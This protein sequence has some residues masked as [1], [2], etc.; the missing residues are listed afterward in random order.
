MDPLLQADK[1]REIFH[2]DETIGS[3]QVY[4]DRIRDLHH[5]FL[6][7]QL[8]GSSSID[9]DLDELLSLFGD[10]KFLAT[11]YTN[12]FVTD[13]TDD[14]P[15]ETTPSRQVIQDGLALSGTIFEYLADLVN[16]FE[17]NPSR[18]AKRVGA[19]LEN[20]RSL[21]LKSGICYG[22]GLYESR[23]QVILKRL[24]GKLTR[25]EKT[26]DAKN[27]PAWSDYLICALMSRSL[28]Q[29][30]ESQT[31]LLGQLEDVRLT[32]KREISYSED[33]LVE[34]SPAYVLRVETALVTIEA[35]LYATDGLLSG[36]E[37]F[38]NQA[39]S[40]FLRAVD[41]AYHQGQYDQTWL[42]RSLSRVVKRMW[43]H[44]PWTQ[45]GTV[46]RQPA[47]LR[48]L[49]DDGYVTLWHSQIEALRMRP[50]P[51]L[52]S[53]HGGYLDERVS[54]VVVSMPTSAGKTLLAEL[55]IAKQL[56][57][58]PESKCIYVAP[59]RALR[60]QVAEKL[61]NRL[62][63]F[64]FRVTSVV[65]D[66]D[67]SDYEGI[68]FN[69]ANVIV[70]TPEKL[71]FLIRQN[72]SSINDTGLFIFDELHNVGKEGRGWTYEE[73]ISLLLQDPTTSSAKMLF[74]SA[75]M[76]NHLAIRQWVDP[77][78]IGDTINVL[79]QPT[80][81]LKGVITFPLK[82]PSAV[83]LLVLDG[84]L[85]YVRNRDEINSPFVVPRII[86]SHQ[87]IIEK[88]SKKNNKTYRAL[89]EKLS[90][91]SLDH[92]VKATQKFVPLG[93]VLIYTPTR[94]AALEFCRR[95]KS[96]TLAIPRMNEHDHH[97]YQE[98]VE[99]I[100]DRLPQGH[101][102]CDVL[103]LRVAFHHAGLP[104]EVRSE[105][106]YA[107]QRGWIHI[108]AA[109]ST[110][111]EGVN[112]PVKT[113]IISDYYASRFRDNNGVP[114]SA[115][116]L[117]EADF[118]NMIGRA[119]RALYETEGQVILI[120]QIV[121]AF[122]YDLESE[123][124]DYLS[125][126]P[127]SSSLDIGSNMLD[128]KLLMLLSR[129]V[130]E[131][132]NGALS[133]EQFLFEVEGSVDNEKLAKLIQR[134]HVFSLLLGERGLVTDDEESFISIFQNTLSGVRQ[135]NRVPTIVGRFAQRSL[136]TAKVK[137]NDHTR[138]LFS[139]TGLKLRVC[140]DLLEKVTKF[141]TDQSSGLD[142]FLQRDRIERQTLYDIAQI[143][144]SLDDD[145]TSPLALKATPK[146]RKYKRLADDS[147]FFAD[148]ILEHDEQKLLSTHFSHMTDPS[149][150]AEQFIRY[151]QQT[152]EMSAPWS[153]SAFWIFSKS[154]LSSLGFDLPQSPFGRELILLPAYAKF[155]VHSPPAALFSSLG[156]SPA[157]LSRQLAEAYI[158]LYPTGR[159]EY[160]QMLSWFLNVESMDLGF[161]STISPMYIRRLQRLRSLL[162]PPQNV[163][164]N[165]RKTRKIEFPIAGWQ[166]Y[167]GDSVIASLRKGSKV[168]LAQE[169]DNEFDS[170]AVS[171]FFENSVKL[172]Y[173]PWHL[174]Q[175]LS[176]RLAMG[177]VLETF[178]SMIQPTAPVYNRAIV[179]CRFTI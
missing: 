179:H 73:L 76:P 90:N 160:L 86:Q 16:W 110:L 4:A 34:L 27:A 46:L 87:Y 50:N 85:I 176:Y 47:Y 125:I 3:F 45:L 33:T 11:Y 161:A 101:V 74:I 42:L 115:N 81:L 99:F 68:L 79:W 39:L 54:R 13:E 5:R 105:I 108:L 178:I 69:R 6:E 136:T 17:E 116:R 167:Q 175:D 51:K 10:A 133:E 40:S 26:L 118:Q 129:L 59:Y 159:Y 95:I 137:L 120:Q 145:E 121:P 98:I 155:G 158:N 83:G 172:G 56:F 104:R 97:E 149:W 61:S 64:G 66:N 148:W 138:S 91:T 65:S 134:L 126:D 117:P 36:E 31:Y 154:V 166:Y 22:L 8:G 77:E 15:V 37:A 147:G 28:R 119:G 29:V 100:K 152:L 71:S 84:D 102:L 93:P 80:R 78:E 143:N 25:P 163:E 21:Y 72:D 62:R 114:T 157:N 123:F 103:D 70:V 113:L 94:E 14:M 165:D 122:P 23:T 67:L 60:D 38:I 41:I 173:V 55:A 9:L 18:L 112:L 24:L 124:Q 106:E 57:S 96:Y 135:P 150:R 19:V 128:D 127:Q 142:L 49:V 131:V 48:Q 88:V 132:D 153:L 89:D 177:S 58:N 30:K 53:S 140:R 32:L 168:Y 174:A 7:T 20:S 63:L 164:W 109:T 75:I 44:S 151:T 162:K 92:A 52:G 111:I 141:W 171:I 43:E 169:P 156:V 144:Y 82:R 146:S 2:H 1:L 107:F 35:C 12:R 130:E 170:N 139:Q